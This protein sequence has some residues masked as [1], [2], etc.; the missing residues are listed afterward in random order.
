MRVIDY[1]DRG[2]ALAPDR[3]MIFSRE[4]R[5]TYREMARLTHR[6]AGAIVLRN[7][8]GEVGSIAV[9]SPN[10]A[11]AFACVLGGLRAGGIWAPINAR[12]HI[13]DNIAFL[14]TADCRWLFIHSRFAEHIARIRAEV[15]TL[16]HVV[17]LDGR[18]D[19]AVDLETFLEETA[20]ELPDVPDDPER[21]CGLFPTG[22]TTGRSKAV[23][24]THRVWETMVATYWS[25]MPAEDPPVYLVAAPMTHAAGVVA[26]PLLAKAATLIVLERADPLEIME[27]I[28]RHRVTDLFLPP[29]VIYSML[30]HP[31]VREFDY[32]S[33]RHFLYAA[34]PIAPDRLAEA[35]QVFGPVMVQSYGQAEAP[36]FCT[37][38]SA[39]DHLVLDDPERRKRLASCGRPT[40]FTRLEIMDD[41]GR[42][43]PPGERGE[44]VVRGNLVMAGYYKDPAATAEARRYGWHHTGDVGYR[45]E[46]G[47][48][49]IID[50]KKDMIITG[51]FNVYSTEVEN[52]ILSHPS[53]QNCVVIGVPDPKWGEAIKAVLELKPGCAV[54]EEEIIALCKSRLGGVK[55]PKS[56]EIWPHLPRSPVGKIL[57]RDIRDRY[58]AGRE[59]MV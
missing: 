43:L 45:D 50:R 3:L 38:L 40:M 47:F 37:F 59:R 14:N 18:F 48:V 25:C 36:M 10:H 19:G 22:G 42:L 2:V 26:I 34:S 55:S 29:T 1:F 30:A 21:V 12:G 57:K 54:A 28:E 5:F 24:F 51:G 41:E 13:D 9:F 33:L 39:R 49:Y 58:W 44:I 17:C 31:R 6:I 46:D 8:V 27:A 11:L 53:V 23:M 15:P 16:E 56:V 35:V 4:H 7:G 52:V 32:S 20:P